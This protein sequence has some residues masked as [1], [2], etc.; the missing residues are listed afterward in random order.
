[1]RKYLA[2]GTA[3]AALAVA[4]C[5][6]GKG[7]KADKV[8]EARDSISKESLNALS[9]TRIFFGHQSVGWNIID[10]L[11]DIAREKAWAGFGFVETRSSA[12]AP[13]FYH[14]EIGQNEDPLGKIEDFVSIMRNGMGD[15]VDIALMKFCYVDFAAD[16]D[17][18]AVFARY[19]DAMRRLAA[20]Y[21][22]VV[23]IWAT[24]PLTAEEAGLK[25]FAKRILGRPT[26]VA[27]NSVRE[28]LNELIRAE[29][30]EEHRPLFDIAAAESAAPQGSR[31]GARYREGE[32]PSLRRD[33]TTD[34]GHLNEVGRKAVAESAL[35]VLASAAEILP[36]R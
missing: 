10:G 31:S 17:A 16:T 19:R 35:V 2:I 12:D 5:D 21:P 28:K 33:F 4:G 7:L 26:R 29:C 23:F 27:E 18:A 15:K 22:R 13:G 6:G 11:K 14:S 36:G 20:E 3:C 9:R 32:S 24:A 30:A 1:M 8:P 25:A 34:G